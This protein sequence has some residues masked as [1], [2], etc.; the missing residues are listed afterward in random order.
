[1]SQTAGAGV[2]LGLIQTADLEADRRVVDDVAPRQQ[3]VGLEDRGKLVAHLHEVVRRRQT[4]D[5][6]RAPGR[7]IDPE[8]HVDERRFATARLAADAHDLALG[9]G[10]RD[11]AH[12]DEPLAVKA[13]V[14]N[15]SDRIDLYDRG[16]VPHSVGGPCR[17]RGRRG[18][19]PTMIET[20]LP[21]VACRRTR[22]PAYSIWKI[23]SSGISLMKPISL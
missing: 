2:A 15:L 1:M 23:P 17:Y 3:P 20:V 21:P 19:R 6:D 12:G 18:E 14:E 5:P 10:E 9:N 8:Q 7:W 13:R 4:V 11:V 16:H 22:S